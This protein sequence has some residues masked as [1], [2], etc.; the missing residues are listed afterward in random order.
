MIIAVAVAVAVA[1]AAVTAISSEPFSG[2]GIRQ[3]VDERSV[4]EG[5]IQPRHSAP[6]VARGVGLAD[7]ESRVALR[8]VV[9]LCKFVLVRVM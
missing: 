5:G 6:R 4:A 3:Q 7:L 8:S 2:A 9:G 1:V